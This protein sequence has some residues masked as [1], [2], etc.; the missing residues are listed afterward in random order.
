MNLLSFLAGVTVG[1]LIYELS[2]VSLLYIRVRLTKSNR[3]IQKQKR[4]C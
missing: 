4:L 2:R 3:E 1:M